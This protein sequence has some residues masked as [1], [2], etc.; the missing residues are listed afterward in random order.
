MEK[1][2]AVAAWPKA[3][4]HTD[5]QL[6]A[7]PV[8][9]GSRSAFMASDLADPSAAVGE[10][11]DET[12]WRSLP[13]VVPGDG[14]HLFAD[15]PEKP[16]WITT[17]VGAKIAFPLKFGDRP[18]FAITYLRGYEGLG[19]ARVTIND[20]SYELEGLWEPSHAK[21]T[22]STTVWWSAASGRKSARAKADYEDGTQGFKVEKGSEHLVTIDFV[23]LKP[24]AI[25]YTGK[26]AKYAAV[27]L[28]EQ[29][30]LEDRHARR[31]RLLDVDGA[32]QPVLEH[33]ER[34]LH[35]RRRHHLRLEVEHGLL[36]AVQLRL[37]KGVKLARL[38]VDVEAAALD[39]LDRRQQLV[40]GTRHHRLGGAAA[41]RDD[42][43]TDARIHAGQ[44]ERRLDGLLPD[45]SGERERGRTAHRFATEACATGRRR[46]R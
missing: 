18:R 45:D 28:G 46:T 34:D 41:A 44:Q 14:W 11:G 20:V 36:A 32:E 1:G 17:T 35:K 8:C 33:V 23:G 19:N 4:L 38:L 30:R 39:L 15:R 9:L 12:R 2:K 26:G 27:R 7:I 13:G 40:H 31:H 43:A 24:Q 3:G 29:P 16:G 42:D 25:T 22:T 5:A 37:Q 21:V 6:E 10:P